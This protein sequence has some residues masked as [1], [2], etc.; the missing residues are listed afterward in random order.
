MLW[1]FQ[2]QY[3]YLLIIIPIMVPELCPLIEYWQIC[4]FDILNIR[5]PWLNVSKIVHN[6]F[7]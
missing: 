2:I 6:L 4:G 5:F 1:N 7:D 3:S